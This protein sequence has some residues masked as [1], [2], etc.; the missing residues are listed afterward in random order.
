LKVVKEEEEKQ[1]GHKLEAQSHLISISARGKPPIGNTFGLR[2]WKLV[3][4]EEEKQRQK[5]G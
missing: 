2:E 1:Q 4:E 3:E 5:V